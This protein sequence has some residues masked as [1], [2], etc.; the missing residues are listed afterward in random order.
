MGSRLS[1]FGL[2]SLAIFLISLASYSYTHTSPAESKSEIGE[3]WEKMTLDQPYAQWT[4]T[5][6]ISGTT[7]NQSTSYPVTFGTGLL[8][9][10]PWSKK[11]CSGEYSGHINTNFY[12]SGKSLDEAQIGI[13]FP[14]IGGEILGLEIN[15]RPLK[16]AKKDYSI[17]GPF[18]T[19]HKQEI[20]S[21]HL[22]VRLKLRSG[23]DFHSGM[24]MGKPIL[25]RMNDLVEHHENQ[26]LINSIIP[27]S[28]SITCC[29]IGLF[30]ILVILVSRTKDSIYFEF[31]WVLLTWGTFYLF[32]SGQIRLWS[33]FVGSFFHFPARTLAS[34]CT[35]RLIAKFSG[36][37][38]SEI[39][40]ISK[41][42]FFLILIQLIAEILDYMWISE[43]AVAF[44]LFPMAFYLL[45][46]ST[47][48]H[49]WLKK[50]VF[51]VTSLESICFLSDSLKHYAQVF[52]FFYPVPYFERHMA[53]LLILTSLIYIIYNVAQ[54]VTLRVKTEAFEEAASQF[55][56]DV[57]SPVAA[58]RL[59]SHT[60]GHSPNDALSII[61]TAIR[62]LTDIAGTLK[63]FLKEKHLPKVQPVKQLIDGIIKEKNFQYKLDNKFTLETHYDESAIGASVKVQAAEFE[64]L[65]SNL[66]NNAAES[67]SQ[68]G[69]IRV[70]VKLND[71]QLLL[72]VTDQ[73]IGISPSILNQIGNRGIT[74]GKPQGSGL[75]LY[76]AKKSIQTWG[77]QFKIIS[78]E[79]EGTRVT[80]ALPLFERA[81]SN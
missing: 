76:H 37:E 27:I 68:G 10:I 9:L 54:D 57:Q 18:V 6:S 41:L 63:V 47:Q 24:W 26:L 35:I 65:L 2:C 29:V 56:H 60:I 36:T 44:L 78:K 14:P 45:V 42:G 17:S 61:T 7:E 3:V 73:G 74:F 80:I 52:H 22:E 79:N 38:Q 16:V 4:F 69:V 32:L 28:Y 11:C 30:F 49:N 25:G 19:L 70:S 40:R 62:R 71:Q 59:A 72:E 43:I 20:R 34:L 50:A 1:S 15:G 75:G 67:M 39:D 55:V 77:G 13:L 46:L 5:P 21:G 23:R 51:L 8:N 33:P 58:L 64:R 12:A 66:I 48:T 31:I 81:Y 53:I